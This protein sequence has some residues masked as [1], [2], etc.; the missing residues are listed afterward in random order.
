MANLQ[1]DILSSDSKTSATAAPEAM[2]VLMTARK[3]FPRPRRRFSGIINSTNLIAR[4][5]LI[6][7]CVWQAARRVGSERE[8]GAK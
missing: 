8:L 1:G 3:A 5:I 4:G 6:L 2:L 7:S